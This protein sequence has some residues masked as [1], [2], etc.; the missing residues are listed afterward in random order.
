MD[1]LQGG[2][3][4]PI[5]VILVSAPNPSTYRQAVVLTATVN[6]SGPTPTGYVIFYNG[7]TSVG[8]AVVT[9]S[10]ATLRWTLL[11]QGSDSI[12]ASYSGNASNSKSTSTIL[13]QTVN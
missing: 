5:T 9:N 11:P 2:G 12:T 6:S 13:I 4:A 3:Y 7:A 1:L 8:N 10:V